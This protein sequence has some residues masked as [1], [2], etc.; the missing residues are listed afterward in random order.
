MLIKDEVRN[1]RDEPVHLLDKERRAAVAG[2]SDCDA[3][4]KVI[5]EDFWISTP[6][7][8]T[9]RPGDPPAFATSSLA[10]YS[11][12]NLCIRLTMNQHEGRH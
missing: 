1:A 5:K 4:Y 10:R 8:S 3:L 7:L 12:A 9:L 11:I 6:C 2:A